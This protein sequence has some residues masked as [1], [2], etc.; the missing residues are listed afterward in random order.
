VALTSRAISAELLQRSRRV[1]GCPSP[2][3]PIV[4]QLVTQPM[5]WRRC[6]LAVQRN[7]VSL[8]QRVESGSHVLIGGVRREMADDVP[9]AVDEGDRLPAF[10]HECV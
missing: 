7:I 4:T 10:N 6:C 1:R 8:G 9:I 2:S 5:P 3:L